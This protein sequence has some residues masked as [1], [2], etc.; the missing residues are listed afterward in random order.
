MESIQR[1]IQRANEELG[2]RIIYQQ[3]KGEREREGETLTY[4][5]LKKGSYDILAPK[6]VSSRDQQ[7]T[8]C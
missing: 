1:T 7:L 4:K 8:S 2:D 5:Y 6:D 3:K